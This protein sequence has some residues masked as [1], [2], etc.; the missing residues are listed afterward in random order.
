MLRNLSK[1]LALFMLAATL[2]T[3]S[4]ITMSPTDTVQAADSSVKL[5]LSN[6]TD[7]FAK[8]VHRAL[9]GNK[10]V[11]I[12]PKRG[13]NVD[14]AKIS[15]LRK[16]IANTYSY[17]VNFD[18]NVSNG[19]IIISEKKAKA[20]SA[21]VKKIQNGLKDAVTESS[22][23]LAQDIHNA[24]M[25]QRPFIF[26]TKGKPT[27]I[28]NDL[29]REVQ[30]INKQDV[31]FKYTSEKVSGTDYYKISIK[32]EQAQ[33]YAYA[34]KYSEKQFNIEKNDILKHVKGTVQNEEDCREG[35]LLECEI[36]MELGE[37][38]PTFEE[39]C[40]GRLDEDSIE[41]LSSRDQM[42]ARAEGMGDLSDIMKLYI[43][44]I[45]SFQAPSGITYTNKYFQSGT[46]SEALMLK[47]LYL[48]KATGVCHDF[49]LHECALFSYWGI[50]VKYCSS[51]NHAW[52]EGVAKNSEGIMVK[53]RFD[54]GLQ[55]PCE[56]GVFRYSTTQHAFLCEEC[57]A[58]DDAADGR[59]QRKSL[60]N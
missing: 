43:I 31:I 1:R 35:Y 53:Y 50:S 58:L 13:Y 27:A 52:T 36:D 45:G 29:I 26:Y 37:P 30:D 32:K 54:Y 7:A 60:V 21:K 25:N 42:I 23:E 3:A 17:G 14:W 55:W 57:E 51:A 12:M 38:V 34:C 6:V 40:D 44:G 48:N 47:N 49:A 5:T 20:Y 46:G 9:M 28:C 56:H 19:I 16:K 10:K 4:V 59:L 11:V 33:A 15:Q 22:S 18:Y 8:K 39:Y 24:L 41:Q 2:L